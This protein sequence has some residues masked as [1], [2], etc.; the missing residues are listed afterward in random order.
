MGSAAS[1]RNGLLN[2]ADAPECV[3][4]P[5]A[6]PADP[7]ATNCNTRTATIILNEFRCRVRANNPHSRTLPPVQQ[8]LTQH[9]AWFNP[10]MHPTMPND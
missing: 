4:G 6:P 9:A 8:H 2:G 3:S 5:P 7:L 1:L 10:S